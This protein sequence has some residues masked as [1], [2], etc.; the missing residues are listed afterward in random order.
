MGIFADNYEPCDKNIYFKTPHYN[1]ISKAFISIISKVY[2]Q[3]NAQRAYFA[4][5]TSHVNI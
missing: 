5:M 4:L 1:C 3:S 2:G